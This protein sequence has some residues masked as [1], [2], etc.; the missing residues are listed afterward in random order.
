MMPM[1]KR[2]ERDT[3]KMTY[4]S[5]LVAPSIQLNNVFLEEVNPDRTVERLQLS[6]SGNQRKMLIVLSDVFRL[7]EAYRD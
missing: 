5:F 6:F 7:V 1:A 2:K 3:E 4:F